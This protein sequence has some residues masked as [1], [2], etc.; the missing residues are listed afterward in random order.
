MRAAASH[1][2]EEGKKVIID[3]AS[4]CQN[5]FIISGHREGF[6]FS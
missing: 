1:V 6:C 5:Y 3:Q 4:I 2:L